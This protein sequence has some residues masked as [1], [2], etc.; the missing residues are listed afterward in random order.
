MN[1]HNAKTIFNLMDKVNTMMN[2]VD[3]LDDAQFMMVMCM[4]FDE[5]HY[6][7]RESEMPEKMARIVAD[8]VEAVNKECGR[9]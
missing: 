1:I 7:H 6:R 9:Y 5:Y 4:I 8:Q 3:D 2:S